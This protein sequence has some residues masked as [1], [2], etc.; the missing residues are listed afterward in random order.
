MK[1]SL[2][3]RRALTTATIGLA[4]LLSACTQ[5]ETPQEVTE[6]FW[7]AA[8]GDDAAAVAR[9]S[10]LTDAEVAEDK[11]FDAFSSEWDGYQ[12]QWGRVIIDGNE[13]SVAS[14]LSR[15]EGGRIR[16]FTTWLVQRDGEWLVDYERTQMSIK[17]GAF[18]DLLNKFDRFSKDLSREF[19]RS[20]DEAGLQMDQVL[21]E[22]ESAGKEM[23]E[24]ASEALEGFSRELQRTLEEMDESLQRQLEEREA[25]PPEDEQPQPESAPVLI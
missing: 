11:A 13:A 23:S 8:I 22:L 19:E 24:Q 5:P 18:G 21:E 2:T 17:G 7:N 6:A 25:Q 9:Y 15:Q 20:A 3:L 12:P 14:T 10:T 4:L 1:L 16:S